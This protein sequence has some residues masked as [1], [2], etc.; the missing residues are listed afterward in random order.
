MEF[1]RDV[2]D[3]ITAYR[4]KLVAFMRR[5]GKRLEDAE[6]IAQE[7]IVLALGNEEEIKHVPAFLGKTALN[8]AHVQNR[9][10]ARKSTFEDGTSYDHF[11]SSIQAKGSNPLAA[12]TLLVKEVVEHVATMKPIFRRDFKLRCI[13]GHS[14]AEMAQIT[15]E[16]EQ[17]HKLRFHR[18]KRK[19]I[20]LVALPTEEPVSPSREKT[21]RQKTVAA[22]AG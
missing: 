11:F 22:T 13:E 1:S 4:P 19:L 20:E 12:P 8:L 2:L 15:G 5:K 10:A 18:M 14:F 3:Q 16:T 21:L 6:D 17:S 7:T 9:I